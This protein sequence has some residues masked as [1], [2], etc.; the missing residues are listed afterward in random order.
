MLSTGI[1]ELRSET[2]IKYLQR[3]FDLDKSEEESGT[4][5]RKL[6]DE[7]RKTTRTQINDF[8]HIAAN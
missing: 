4:L 2:D 1:P 8:I 6:I 7:A 3:Q 5:F